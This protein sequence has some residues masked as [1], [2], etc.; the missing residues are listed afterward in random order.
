MARG[1]NDDT[2]A[3]SEIG[4]IVRDRR[5]A[6]VHLTAPIR[7]PSKRSVQPP[8]RSAVD[9]ALSLIP[10]AVDFTYPEAVDMPYSGEDAVRHL[11]DIS[12][13]HP[14]GRTGR[15][16]YSSRLGVRTTRPSIRSMRSSAPQPS[17]C[18]AGTARSIM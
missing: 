1:V 18:C 8:M 13:T 3:L 12:G 2:A 9:M 16:P 7:P 15:P 10:G 17:F 6:E 14:P 4:E 11:L 5:P